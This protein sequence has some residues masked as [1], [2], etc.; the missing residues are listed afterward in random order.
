MNYLEIFYQTMEEAKNIAVAT[1]VKD[2][3]NVRIMDFAYDK[4][5]NITYVATFK[6]NNK[7]SEFNKNANVSFTTLPDKDQ[8]HVRSINAKI[9]KSKLSIFEIAELLIKKNHGFKQTLDMAGPMLEVFEIQA[10]EFTVIPDIKNAEM[11]K[12]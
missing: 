10:N 9:R 1:S 6:N 11:I 8:K 7:V 4:E 12:L 5:K 2:L 3:P